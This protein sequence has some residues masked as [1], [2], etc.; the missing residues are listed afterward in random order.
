MP[1]PRA[2]FYTFELST[3]DLKSTCFTVV[4][5]GFCV[6]ELFTWTINRFTW[7]MEMIVFYSSSHGLYVWGFSTWTINCSYLDHGIN[8]S[9]VV[10]H[11]FHVGGI[12]TWTI[13]RF[14]LDHVNANCFTLVA[15]GFH[16]RGISTWTIN[17]FH[18]TMEMTSF[19]ISFP[20]GLKGLE[21]PKV[22][23]QAWV[24]TARVH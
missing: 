4:F 18:G 17:R 21:L 22:Q 8:V 13:N 20:W 2:C 23:S 11:G 15:H 14:Y 19:Y 24:W 10:F 6:E 7:T 9:A 5:P 16:V 1:S 3:K 12:S